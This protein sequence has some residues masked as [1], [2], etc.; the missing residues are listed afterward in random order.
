ML[1]HL[2]WLARAVRLL[3]LLP[4]SLHLVCTSSGAQDDLST[5]YDYGFGFEQ[6][7]RYISMAADM[8]TV[9]CNLDYVLPAESNSI[10]W[11]ASKVPSKTSADGH[12]PYLL[13]R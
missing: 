7:E 10:S 4:V 13:I 5:S 6:R 8:S 3:V 2:R 1:F 9:H 11:K 12:T